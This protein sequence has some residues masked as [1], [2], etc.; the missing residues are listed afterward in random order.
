MYYK[1]SKLDRRNT[2]YQHFTHRV[3]VL[4]AGFGN[5]HSYQPRGQRIADFNM[6]RSWCWEQFGPSVETMHWEDLKI[7]DQAHLAN[8]KWAWYIN[9][10]DSYRTFLYFAD[11]T[12]LSFFKLNWPVTSKR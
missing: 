10:H 8:D 3:E 11:E 2:W 5:F 9:A 1:V 12:S 7:T 4:R 6:L